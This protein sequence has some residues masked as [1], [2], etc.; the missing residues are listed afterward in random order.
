M[1]LVNERN[2]AYL[3]QVNIMKYISKKVSNKESYEFDGSTVYFDVKKYAVDADGFNGKPFQPLTIDICNA[4]V[5][6][7]FYLA[8][9]GFKPRQGISAQEFV[10]NRYLLYKG[11]LNKKKSSPTVYRGCSYNADKNLSR[12]KEGLK[13]PRMTSTMKPLCKGNRCKFCFYIAHDHIGFFLVPG[14]NMEHSHH[15]RLL[16]K[17]INL[18]TRFLSDENKSLLKEMGVIKASSGVS[19][20]L[21]MLRTGKYL[22]KEKIRWMTDLCTCLEENNNNKDKLNSTEKMM[23]YLEKKNWNT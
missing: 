23:R 12:G 16:E 6:S 5:K 7:G 11:D 22:S 3:P 15:P 14:G 1:C 20:N 2:V 9:N 17:E 13:M 19:S 21:M 4:A 10:C 18:P 8:K